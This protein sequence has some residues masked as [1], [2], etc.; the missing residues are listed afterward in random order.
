M[1]FRSPASRAVATSAVDESSRWADVYLVAGGRALSVCGD[2]LA[3]TTLALV[4]QQS[5]HGG[6]AVSGLMLAAAL[7]LA[8]LAPVAGR[9]ADRADSR[10]ILVGVGLAQALVCVALAFIG[11]PVLIIGMVA[12]LAC[13][14]AVTQ[15]TIAALLPRMV[16]RSELARASGLN[17]TAGMLGMLIA[18]ALAGFLVGTTGSRVP[19]LIDACTYLGLV[20]VGL[21]VRTR[22]RGD[23][24]AQKDRT[25]VF[26]LRADRQILVMTVATAAVVA[27]VGAI[28]VVDVFFVRE[29]L[30]ASA[31]LYGLVA[32]AWTVGM[33]LAGPLVGRMPQRWL[34]IRTFLALLALSCA[35]VLAGSTVS[36]AAWLIPLWIIGGAGNG[37][38]NVLTS[39]MIATRV[40]ESA[41]GRAFSAFGAAVQGAG[42][43][44]FMVAGP[45]LD[46]FDPRP[47]VAAA[48]AAGLL[49]ALICL[50]LV[51]RETPGRPPHSDRGEIRDTVAA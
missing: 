23:E 36:G 40:P 43:I 44:G 2:F 16:S 22:R 26:R 39:V 4:L 8:L 28:N 21:L 12:L 24:S 29:T 38:V 46:R 35:A 9:L 13:G 48:G 32:A 10:K 49:A 30:A 50:P 11:D 7:P 14:L 47:L 25:V 37:G 17:Q 3:A 5:G 41:H 51:R 33:L 6:F 34:T 18:P 19:L 20:A 27:G 31:T 1:S 42:L 15:P 45:L